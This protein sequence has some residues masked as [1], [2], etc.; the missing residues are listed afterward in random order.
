M[1]PNPILNKVRSAG[2]IGVSLRTFERIYAAGKIPCV[3]LSARRVGFRVR[4]LERYL[5]DRAGGSTVAALLLIVA[6]CVAALLA[7]GSL[8]VL[9]DW[10]PRVTL[11]LLAGVVAWAGWQ[12]IGG[13]R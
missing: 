7:V 2:Y 11:A 12:C 6:L 8:A 4:D 10:W 5:S 1:N 9:L 13:G 3:R